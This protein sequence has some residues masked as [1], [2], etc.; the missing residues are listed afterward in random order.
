MGVSDHQ[1]TLLLVATHGLRDL[2]SVAPLPMH[3]S[4]L[5]GC[6]KPWE[7]L[8]GLEAEH[9]IPTPWCR[10]WLYGHS[11]LHGS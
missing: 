10:A 3:H 11:Q 1:M 2:P 8:I 5:G 9:I 4:P 6:A 7:V